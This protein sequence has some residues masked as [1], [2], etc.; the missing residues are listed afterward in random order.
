[1]DRDGVFDRLGV[2]AGHRQRDRN[3]ASR[4]AP[5]TPFVAAGEPAMLSDRR[6]ET[7]A[8][9]KGRRRPGR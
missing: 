6:P 4:Q 9:V 1:M 3:A 2:A 7:V 8:G 5:K